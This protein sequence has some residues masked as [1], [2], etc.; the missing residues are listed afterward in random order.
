MAKSHAQP[1]EKQ[2]FDDLMDFLD[3][4]FQKLPDRRANNSTRYDLTDVL[5]SAFAMLGFREK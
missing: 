5:K 3:S 4:Q 1:L 2:R